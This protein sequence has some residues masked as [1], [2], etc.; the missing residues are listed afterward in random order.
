MS[1][2]AAGSMRLLTAEVYHLLS[3]TSNGTGRKTGV[4]RDCLREG[5]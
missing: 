5:G 3:S 1:G 2:K 4:S